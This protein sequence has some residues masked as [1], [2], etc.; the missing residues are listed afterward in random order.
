MKKERGTTTSH[1]VSVFKPVL[2]HQI[3]KKPMKNQTLNPLE[4]GHRMKKKT[5]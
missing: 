2:L 5:A 4:Q 1:K 3:I